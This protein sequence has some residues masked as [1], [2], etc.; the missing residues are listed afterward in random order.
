[1]SSHESG[2]PSPWIERFGRL[3]RAGGSVLDVAS[4]A[5]RH[6]RWFAA[7]GHR[8]TAI[9]RD[10]AALGALAGMCGTAETIVFDLETDARWPLVGRTFDAVVV[11]NYLHR[12]LFDDLLAVLAPGGVLLYE[13]FAAG[14]ARFG[15]PSNPA[16]LLEPG[17]LLVRCAVLDVVA[18]EDGLDGDPPRASVQRLCAVR[19]PGGGETARHAL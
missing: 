12:P 11:T 13:T 2:A 6:S 19:R 3:V 9:D 16:F 18:F 1:M 10:E 14:N 17:E 8:V 7:R 15:R 5:G 4:G